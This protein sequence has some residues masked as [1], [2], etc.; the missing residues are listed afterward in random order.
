[1][2]RPLL[3]KIDTVHYTQMSRTLKVAE[4]YASRLLQEH[5]G[6]ENGKALARHLVEKYPEHG[7]VIDVD[8]AKSI[9]LNPISPSEEQDAIMKEVVR[10]WGGLNVIGRLKECPTP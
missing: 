3:E 9:G 4:E 6:D 8:E 10:N 1:M 2:M 7:F 5:H